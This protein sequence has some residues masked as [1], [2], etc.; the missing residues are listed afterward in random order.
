MGDVNMLAAVAALTALEDKEH[1]AWEAQENAEIRDE[2]IG[3]FRE[4]EAMRFQTQTQT[5]FS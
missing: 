3:F 1:I 5:I 2:V 4:N